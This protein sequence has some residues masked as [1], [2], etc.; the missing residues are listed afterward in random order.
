MADS[1]GQF[2]GFELLD[3]Y[4]LFTCNWFYHIILQIEHNIN[5]L[6]REASGQIADLFM[7]RLFLSLLLGISTNAWSFTFWGILHIGFTFLFACHEI[8]TGRLHSYMWYDIFE[9]RT[10]HH[11]FVNLYLSGLSACISWCF[12]WKVFCSDI[13]IVFGLFV[14]IVLAHLCCKLRWAFLVS[15]CMLPVHLFVCILTFFLNTKWAHFNQTWLKTSVGIQVC[16]HL[17]H[18][19]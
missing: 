17:N 4:D 11:C 10:F 16:L 2:L 12:M 18:K 3:L 19:C 1:L 15:F 14:F 13:L 7:K 8:F 9:C 5:D 6:I